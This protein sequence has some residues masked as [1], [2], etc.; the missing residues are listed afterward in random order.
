MARVLIVDDEPAVRRTVVRFLRRSGFDV[1]EAEDGAAALKA[2][3]NV[4]PDVV[5]TD[6][7]MPDMDGIELLAALR[8]GDPELP[9][10][11]I[12]G[13][14]VIPKRVLLKNANMLG[15]TFTIAKPFTMD[16]ILEVVS[17]ALGGEEE[18]EA[19]AG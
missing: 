17:E 8:S 14:G 6:V 2:V 11:V 4:R 18:A 1:D 12:S 16:E 15:A 9:V 10:I 7:N 13:G 5:I 3:A 19:T